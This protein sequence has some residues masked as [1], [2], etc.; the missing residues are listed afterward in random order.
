MPWRE[1]REEKQ[2]FIGT[3]PPTL[4]EP[5]PLQEHRLP[6]WCAGDKL[7]SGARP[8]PAGVRWEGRSLSKSHPLFNRWL[9]RSCW[10]GGSLGSCEQGEPSHRCQTSPHVST[11]QLHAHTF[12]APSAARPE[13]SRTHVGPVEPDWPSQKPALLPEREAGPPGGSGAKSN[14]AWGCRRQHRPPPAA[15]GLEASRAPGFLPQGVPEGPK[16][17]A[18]AP[19]AGAGCLQR[20]IADPLSCQ[21]G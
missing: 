4:L 20:V 15:S 5:P 3:G 17:T 18:S 14:R 11:A 8:E 19:K 12:T 7:S 10:E 16:L 21:S 6:R 2:F 9:L 13:A 1:K